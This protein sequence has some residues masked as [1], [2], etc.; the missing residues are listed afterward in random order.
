ML[1]YYDNIPWWFPE[2]SGEPVLSLLVEKYQTLSC[3]SNQRIVSNNKKMTKPR[4]TLLP[5]CYN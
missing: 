1:A 3:I 2:D 5:A 4:H